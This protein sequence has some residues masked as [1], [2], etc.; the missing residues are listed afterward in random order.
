MTGQPIVQPPAKAS[1]ST[2]T[3]TPAIRKSKDNPYTKP[4]VGK[5][6]RCGEQE[7]KSNQC[8]KRRQVNMTDYEEGD[9]VLVKTEPEDSDFIE[10]YGDHI[11]C[12]IQKV[13]CSQKIPDTQ[14]H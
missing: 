6:Y 10:E 9:D 13:L 2:P 12:V 5:C 14:R 3:T 11:T 1:T 7:H 8:P 4:E